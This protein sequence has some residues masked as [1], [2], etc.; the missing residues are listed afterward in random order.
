MVYIKCVYIYNWAASPGCASCSAL[1]AGF[2]VPWWPH[3]QEPRHWWDL[4]WPNWVT[5]KNE[6]KFTWNHNGT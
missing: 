1:A 2:T 5:G 4:P 3:G 6:R